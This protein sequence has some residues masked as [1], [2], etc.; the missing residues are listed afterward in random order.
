MQTCTGLLI[1]LYLTYI[2]FSYPLYVI[3]IKKRVLSFKAVVVTNETCIVRQKY[4]EI[5]GEN[6]PVPAYIEAQ[7]RQSGST[8]KRSTDG[9]GTL[10]LTFTFLEEIPFDC[11]FDCLDRIGWILLFKFY[12]A[13]WKVA[14]G[15][16]LTV[17]NLETSEQVNVTLN[18]ELQP[19]RDHPQVTCT[20]GRIL[21]QDQ[22]YCS[23]SFKSY[24]SNL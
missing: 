22:E 6:A 4:K 14:Y 19:E 18:K 5:R 16:T 24:T 1:Y 3:A 7:C 20:S 9:V 11:N 8:R 10:I 17:T 21:S 23:K 13:Q 12:E 2:Y 15:L